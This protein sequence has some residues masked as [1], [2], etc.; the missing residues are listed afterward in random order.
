MLTDSPT[1][2]TVSPPTPIFDAPSPNLYEILDTGKHVEIPVGVKQI[3]LAITLHDLIVASLGPKPTGK[4]FTEML[5]RMTPPRKRAFRP[6]VAYVSFE[7]WP[8]REFPDTDA[9]EIVPDLAVEIVSKSNSATEVQ[10]KIGEYL[11]AGVRQV[12]VVFPDQRQVVVYAPTNTARIYNAEDTLESPEILP[13]FQ[14]N[15]CELLPVVP[16]RP[17]E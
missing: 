14:L 16:E 9:W 8:S 5:Y 10:E 6:D 15:V 17:E 13:A 11:A 1:L 3:G 7:R 4:S 12:W 2:P